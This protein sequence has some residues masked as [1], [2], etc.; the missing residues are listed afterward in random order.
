M[1]NDDQMRAACFL[2]VF[3]TFGSAELLALHMFHEI[4]PAHSQLNYCSKLKG[5]VQGVFL[6]RNTQKKYPQLAAS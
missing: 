4:P 3:E 6:N 2:S 1:E 5:L